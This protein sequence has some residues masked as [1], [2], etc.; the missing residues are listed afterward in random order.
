MDVVLQ[1]EEYGMETTNKH[2]REQINVYFSVYWNW[3]KCISE[4][5][6][7]LDIRN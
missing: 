4:L 3:N 1:I 7:V 5:E 2:E 6:Y